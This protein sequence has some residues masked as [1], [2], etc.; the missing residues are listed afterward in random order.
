MRAVALA[1][2][3]ASGC[4]GEISGVERGE[5]LFTSPSLSPS[6]LNVFAC[7]TC[8]SV[9]PGDTVS[10]GLPGYRLSGVPSRPTYWGGDYDL[11]REAV[12]AC[13]VFFMKGEPLDPD[14][15][16]FHALYEYLLSLGDLG[17]PTEALPFTVVENIVDVPRGDRSAGEAVYMR[18][19]QFCH[20]DA[21]TSGAG[22]ILRIPVPLPGIVET[23][24]SLFPG[25]DPSLVIIEKVRHGRFFSIGGEMPLFS[26]EALS[27]DELGALLSYLEL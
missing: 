22:S 26:L 15:D 23:Y 9:E 11:L 2:L 19:C 27:D 24:P 4:T 12:N 14:S 13:L 7:A 5:E 20:G 25:V 18:S 21:H 1:A 10:G 6:S 17:G 8:H 3:V 16:D